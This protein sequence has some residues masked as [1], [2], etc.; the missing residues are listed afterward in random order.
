MNPAQ[1]TEVDRFDDAALAAWHAVLDAA[2][3]EGVEDVATVWTL[4]ELT[5][6]LR[7]PSRRRW[8][9]AYVARIGA[10]VVGAGWFSV[11]LL[12]NLDRAEVGVGV[13]SG[14]RRRGVGRALLAHLEGIARE[15]GRTLLDG[16]A[17]WPSEYDDE[18]TG[19]PGAEFARAQGF[20]LALGDMQ[21]ELALPVDEALLADLAA[22]AAPHH[23][24]FLLRSWVGAVP[25]EL[26]PSWLALSNTLMTEA[27]TGE[28]EVED[29]GLDV[30]AMRE[31]DALLV[32]QGRTRY[33]TVALDAAGDVVAYTD[34]G[35]T[36]HEPGRAY[37]WGTLVRRDERGHRL[38]LAVKVANLQLIQ[39]ERDD[40]QRM[41]TW[42]AEVNSHMIDVNERLGFRPVARLGEFQKR[43]L[44]TR[45]TG[46][47]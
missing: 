14:S 20:T 5:L 41:F 6:M 45:D 19:W 18:G 27:P 17:Q 28:R 23:R 30:A 44:P 46:S 34:V 13:E 15:R 4:P 11:P 16:E 38:G 22:D 26:A 29:E 42:N 10:R 37:Q 36:V 35:V 8:N 47:H 3:R 21:R 39:R 2:A 40:L 33:N 9:A 32:K 25:D 31:S 7:E 24:D 12:D 43:V 1:I